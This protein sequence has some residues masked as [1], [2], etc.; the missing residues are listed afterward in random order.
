MLDL[1]ACRKL[2]CHGKLAFSYVSDNFISILVEP[3]IYELDSL[4]Y[5][6]TKWHLQ[7]LAYEFRMNYA[8]T[9]SS[10]YANYYDAGMKGLHRIGCNW[11]REMWTESKEWIHSLQRSLGTLNSDLI[12]GGIP[13]EQPKVEILDIQ[14]QVRE[15]E[16]TRSRSRHQSIK[17]GRKVQ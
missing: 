15:D 10:I 1:H 13:V 17:Q 2:K 6:T 12:I 5:M 8:C 3:H 14:L 9:S 4:T 11:D 16:L 7:K